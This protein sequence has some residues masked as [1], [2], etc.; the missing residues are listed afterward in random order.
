MRKSY[1]KEVKLQAVQMVKDGK[2][3]AEVAR[4]L[5]DAHVLID[6]TTNKPVGEGRKL[7]LIKGLFYV[8]LSG[9]FKPVDD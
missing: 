6:S 5:T 3:L 7:P 4:E 1:D 8:Y 2:R 9:T